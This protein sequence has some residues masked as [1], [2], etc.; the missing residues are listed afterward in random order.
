VRQR[1]GLSG[2]ASPAPLVDVI[3]CSSSFMLGHRAAIVPPSPKRELRRMDV[4][5]VTLHPLPSDY[6]AVK[7]Y[8]AASLP[9]DSSLSKKAVQALVFALA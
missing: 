9:S 6:V 1:T 2:R 3:G 4:P 7:F 8:T 5:D